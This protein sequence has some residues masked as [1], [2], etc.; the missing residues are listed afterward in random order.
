MRSL[1][2]PM[3]IAI[4]AITCVYFTIMALLVALKGEW[5]IAV[6]IFSFVVLYF[7]TALLSYLKSKKNNEKEKRNESR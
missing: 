7:S 3:H 6:V 2:T 4:D 5:T 1:R